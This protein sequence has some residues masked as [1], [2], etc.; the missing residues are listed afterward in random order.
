[1]LFSQLS[2]S[3]FSKIYPAMFEITGVIPEPILHNKE[4]GSQFGGMTCLYW[5]SELW[6]RSSARYR[7][8][9]G[10]SPKRHL[11]GKNLKNVRIE[12]RSGRFLFAVCGGSSSPLLDA[13]KLG[14]EAAHQ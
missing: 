5:K 14:G 13:K 12:K 4:A 1:V 11:W 9:T 3:G 2:P 6:R 10:D 7:K 8:G